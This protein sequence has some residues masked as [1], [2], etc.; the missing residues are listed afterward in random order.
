MVAVLV[1]MVAV[2]A[3]GAIVLFSQQKVAPPSKP[4]AEQAEPKL[5]PVELKV[6]SLIE[7]A[8][9][10]LKNDMFDNAIGKCEQALLLSANNTEVLQ[11]KSWIAKERRFKEIVEQAE[12]H[13]TEGDPKD[14]LEA[15]RE[16]SNESK[17]HASALELLAKFDAL[18]IQKQVDEAENMMQ[19]RQYEESLEIVNRVLIRKPGHIQ[20]KRI[21]IICEA[22]LAGKTVVTAPPPSAV[23]EPEPEPPKREPVAPPPPKAEPKPSSPPPPP[24]T[25]SA[26]PAPQEEEHEGMHVT[27]Q[28]DLKMPIRSF[29]RQKISDAIEEARA[30]STGWGYKPTIR[31]AS[32][33]LNKL[34]KFKKDWDTGRNAADDNEPSKA[35]PKLK[36]A[37]ATAR[38]IS[39]DSD[40]EKDIRNMLGNMYYSLGKGFE[41]EQEWVKAAKSYK[42][43]LTAKPGHIRASRAMED[44]EVTA[45]KLYYKGLA[46]KNSDPEEAKKQWKTVKQLVTKN[47][48]WY[49]KAEEGLQ[50][51]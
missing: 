44:L 11:L 50:S 2:V 35:I 39:A 37:W 19:R 27:G 41:G 34:T 49:L 40:Y 17:Y 42:R 23:R 47:S 25:A 21:K 30:I 46:A 13:L 10:Q 51:L 28:G 26:P 45:K 38:E 20:A 8:R 31:E 3:V 33:L 14:S 9:V 32:N 18:A 36:S 7:Q 29:Q 24:K 16:V 48:K 12:I 43:A 4:V 15:L 1:A 5:D 6:K 22:K